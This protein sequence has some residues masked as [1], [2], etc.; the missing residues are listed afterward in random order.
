MGQGQRQFWTEL[1]QLHFA[2]RNQTCVE[3]Q[4]DV[5]WW[6]WRQELH[7]YQLEYQFEQAIIEH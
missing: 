6:Q 2:E 7:Q 3:E 5:V 1:C 4:L